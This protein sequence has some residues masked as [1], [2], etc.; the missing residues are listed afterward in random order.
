M[1]DECIL[2]FT[3]IEEN[4]A[5]IRC[6]NSVYKISDC[7]RVFCGSCFTDL[8]KQ[9]SEHKLLTCCTGSNCRMLFKPSDVKQIDI[10]CYNIY[11]KNIL[12]YLMY[13]DYDDI[14]KLLMY[15]K[16]IQDIRNQRMKHIQESYP[17]SVFVVANIVFS[18]K[19]KRVNTKLLKQKQEED[20]QTK[21][22][23][24]NMRCNGKLSENDTYVLVCN[25]CDN[26]FCKK[27]E[28]IY[29][30][31]QHVCNEQDIESVE[32]VNSY[33]RCPECAVPVEKNMG[34]RSI[35]CATCGTMFDYYTGEKGHYGGHSIH[36]DMRKNY[37]LTNVYKDNIHDNETLNL[38]VTFESMKPSEPSDKSYKLMLKTYVNRV[39]SGTHVPLAIINM[40]I[41]KYF[42]F[43]TQRYKYKKYM[44]MSNAMEKELI[45]KQLTPEC[46]QTSIDIMKLT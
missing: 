28:K 9:S 13:T 1:S 3:E 7:S 26:K 42:A 11:I 37:R 2:C 44:A 46:V 4:E 27:C 39:N 18:D 10:G 22:I 31:S 38:L 23:C 15:D 5:R 35:T 43:I 30:D 29:E 14:N 16:L 17:S 8:L 36:F 32:L 24:L 40:L 12:D 25:I 20:A 33:I 6:L 19:L 45:K 41:N 34:C 21:R